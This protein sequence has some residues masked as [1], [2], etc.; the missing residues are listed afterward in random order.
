MATYYPTSEISRTTVKF[1][2][3]RGLTLEVMDGI[4][5]IYEAGNDSEYMFSLRMMAGQFFFDGYTYLRQDI[6]EELPAYYPDEKALR[7]M[8]AFVAKE[9]AAK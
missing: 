2:E 1:A 6:K 8:L 5:E 3:A 4:L 9:L 7:L